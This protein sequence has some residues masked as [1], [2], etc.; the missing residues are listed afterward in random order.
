MHRTFLENGYH[1]FSLYGVTDSKCDCGNDDCQAL[2]KHP[3]ISNWPASPLWSDEQL[4][5][6]EE[7]DQFATGYGV[8][9]KNLIVLDVDQ[10]NGGIPAFDRLSKLIPEI[11]GAGLIVNTGSGGGSRHLYF[12]A[13]QDVALERHLKEYKGLDFQ[14]G[15]SFVVGP[16]SMHKSGNTY[17]VAVGSPDDIDDAPQALIDLLTKP[18]RHRVEYSGA[19]MDVSH[20]DVANMVHHIAN[21][22]LEY[23]EYIRIGMAIHHVLNG[24]GFAIWDEWSQRSAKYDDKS[25]EMKWHSFGRSAMP[26]TVGTLIHFAEQGGW[27]QP[28]EFTSDTLAIVDDTTDPLDTSGVDLLR[29]PGFVGEVVAWINNDQ[30]RYLRENLAVAAALVGIGNVAGLRYT[31][32]NGD[33]STNL[34]CFCVAPSGSGK[35][36]ILQSMDGIHLAAGISAASVGG[37]KSEQEITKNLIRHQAAFYVIDELGYLLRKLKNA[38]TKGSASY[39]EGV[40]ASLMS[41]YSKVNSFMILNGDVKDD[42]RKILIQDASKYHKMIENNEDKTGRA[43]SRLAGIER[44]LS[45]LDQGLE[46]PFVSIIGFTTPSTFDDLMDFEQ[47]TNGFMGRAVLFTERESNPRAKRGFKKKPMSDKMQRQLSALY[48]G[49]NFDQFADRIEH[50]GPRIKIK[51]TPDAIDALGLAL[52]WVENYAEQQKS[53]TG[54]EAIVKRGYEFV[55]KISL[56]LAVQEGIRTVEHVRWA[57]ALMQRDIEDKMKLVVSNDVTHGQDLQLMAKITKIISKDHGEKLGVIKNRL[58]KYKA[59]DV[60]TALLKMEQGGAAKKVDVLHKKNNS[61]IETWFAT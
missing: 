32:D 44:Q 58:R 24:D 45:T 11:A 26:V 39:L 2:Y 20:Q 8:L 60:E 51:S 23:D 28:V 15:N 18:E 59:S 4:D 49:G 42:M 47:A 52:D 41:A 16:N 1:I 56:I 34:F 40:I 27:K 19:I 50:Y 7:T 36:A 35:E 13:P 48:H 31:D 9:C 54:L 30:C 55:A 57:F 61:T 10:R 12:K 22:N 43:G 37:I 25:M 46:K 17:T 29:P 38:M 53:A 21:D 14:S 33:V 3:R 6:M 5:L